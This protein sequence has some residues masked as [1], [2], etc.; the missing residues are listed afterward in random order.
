MAQPVGESSRLPTHRAQAADKVPG[1]WKGVTLKLP[2]A[3]ALLLA[4]RKAFSCFSGLLSEGHESVGM[5]CQPHTS[6]VLHS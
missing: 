1:Q 5:S 6:A 2:L 4:Y 3:E